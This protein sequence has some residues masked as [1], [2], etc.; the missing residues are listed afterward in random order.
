MVGGA[1]LKGRRAGEFTV[2]ISIREMQNHLA[3]PLAL[4]GQSATGNGRVG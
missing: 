4:R 2:L 1:A 3:A